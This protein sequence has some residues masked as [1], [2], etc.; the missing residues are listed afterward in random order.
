LSEGLTL[1]AAAQKSNMTEP[2]ARRYRAMDKLP[3]EVE[4]DHHWRT[5]KDPLD[6]V[7]SEIQELLEVA[8]DLQATTLLDWLKRQWPD[9]YNDSHLR[10]LQRRIKQWRAIEGPA[11]EVVFAQQHFPGDLCA[12]DFTHMASL[13]VTISGQSFDHMAY[14]FVLTYSNW[15]SVTVCHSESFESLSEGLQRALWMLKGVPKRH[16]TDRLS[17]AVNNLS[18]QKEFTQRYQ[19]LMDHYGLAMEKIRPR[20]AHENGDVESSHR[21]FKKA[22]DQALLMRGSREFESVS[23]YEQFLQEIVDRRNL[24]RKKRFDEELPELRSLPEERVASFRRE[25]MRVNTGSLIHIQYNV[26]SVHSRLIG[27]TVEVRI[28]A[29]HIEIWYAQRRVDR[30]PR[31]RGRGKQLINYRHIIDTLVRKPGAFEN[32]RYRE[33][34]FPTSRFRMAYDQLRESHGPKTAVREYLRILYQAAHDSE[35]GVDEALR[36]LQ[37]EEQPVSAAAVAQLLHKKFTA[38]LVTDVTVCQPDLSSF[39]ELLSDVSVLTNQEGSHGFHGCES[40][41]CQPFAAATPTVVS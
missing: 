23:Q 26:Y 39:D 18:E 25:T 7:W 13:N 29:N 36:L 30:F 19:A 35:T 10:T 28:C 22:V 17:A 11:K 3:S 4:P 37:M 40:D 27:E 8:P 5:R 34:L 24:G 9:K 6:E 12:S 15:E 14:H 31:L 20:E 38:P 16:R 32:Y 1:R 2:T 21:H 41:A 33:E